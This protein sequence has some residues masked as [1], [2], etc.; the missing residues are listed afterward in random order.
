[1]SQTCFFLCKFFFLTL[2]HRP[3]IF[4]Y[5]WQISFQHLIFQKWSKESYKSKSKGIHC[6]PTKFVNTFAH[7]CH[8][9]GYTDTATNILIWQSFAFVKSLLAT[10][11]SDMKLCHDSRITTC[12]FKLA[13]VSDYYNCSKNGICYF[14]NHTRVKCV[15]HILGFLIFDYW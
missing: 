1:M 3:L 6:L 4:K 12:S 2:S 13:V 9:W 14:E 8:C 11:T 15:V 7:Q 10:K 5:R